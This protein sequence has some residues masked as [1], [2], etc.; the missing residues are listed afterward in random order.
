MTKTDTFR[1]IIS[2]PLGKSVL[3]VYLKITHEISKKGKEKKQQKHLMIYE[4]F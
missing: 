4:E 2:K 3:F 1:L